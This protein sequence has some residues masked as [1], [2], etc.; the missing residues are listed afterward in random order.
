MLATLA[1]CGS[2]PGLRGAR[3]P[4]AGTVTLDGEPVPFALVE[5]SRNEANGEIESAV[6]QDGRFE[7][8]AGGGL[9][10][11]RYSVAILPYVPEVE[12]TA[13]MTSEQRK[14]I[15]ASQA[16]VPEGYH[17]RGALTADVKAESPNELT[18]AM[19]KGGP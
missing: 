17:R 16:L 1:G 3:T 2:R 4:V 14:T 7:L 5:F 19:K 10:E 12:E 13:S 15:A 8:K 11:G 9:P 6:V 18:F